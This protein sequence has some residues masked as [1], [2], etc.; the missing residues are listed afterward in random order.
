MAKVTLDFEP[1]NIPK[2]VGA[3][4]TLAMVAIPDSIA[5]AI[6]A[7]VNPIKINPGPYQSEFA[8]NL[9]RNGA[10]ASESE[11]AA[12]RERAIV[13]LSDGGAGSNVFKR[14]IEAYLTDVDG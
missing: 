13:G 2:D 14:T 12:L 8:R 6:L 9:V 7:G 5:S 3:G 4:L 11:D 1:K 10:H